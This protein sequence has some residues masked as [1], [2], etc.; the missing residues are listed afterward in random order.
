MRKQTSFDQGRFTT[1]GVAYHGNE[2]EDV[3]FSED[4][5]YMPFPAKEQ[6]RFMRLKGAK[7]GKRVAYFQFQL[8]LD[9]LILLI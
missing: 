2:A 9:G 5:L 4:L 7:A 8:R 3:Q 1:S 6:M